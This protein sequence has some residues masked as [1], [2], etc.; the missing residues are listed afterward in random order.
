VRNM[1]TLI[2]FRSFENYSAQ[3]KL[4]LP[5]LAGWMTTMPGCVM[6]SF[7]PAERT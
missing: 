5:V 2:G 4:A 3:Q 7:S 1:R 6:V